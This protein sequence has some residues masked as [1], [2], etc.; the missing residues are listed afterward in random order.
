[1]ILRVN[2]VP[3]PCALSLCPTAHLTFPSAPGLYG[4]G[5]VIKRREYEGG[6]Q[7]VCSGVVCRK[8]AIPECL[9]REKRT[10]GWPGDMTFIGSN[11]GPGAP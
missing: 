4:K 7:R 11:T 3:E 5:K 10:S 8:D 6:T 2:L 9:L 1:M